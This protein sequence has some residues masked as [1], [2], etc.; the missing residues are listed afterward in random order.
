MWD[1]F[2]NRL[3]S[4]L[5]FVGRVTTLVYVFCCHNVPLLLLLHILGKL[6][7]SLVIRLSF[8]LNTILCI[9]LYVNIHFAVMVSRNNFF[10]KLL[11][12]LWSLAGLN[13]V[14]VSLRGLHALQ[15]LPKNSPWLILDRW[16]SLVPNN[17]RSILSMMFTPK[18]KAVTLC[19][20]KC[21]AGVVHMGWRRIVHIAGTCL[22]L[23]RHAIF[24]ASITDPVLFCHLLQPVRL[25][26]WPKKLK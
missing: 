1:L 14:T 13:L 7:P 15:R 4:T 8:P 6:R 12:S 26:T 3:D 25:L 11:F 21:L 17:L 22:N 19:V 5:T 9:V 24:G 20:E 10:N 18:L 16:K 2:L 23:H